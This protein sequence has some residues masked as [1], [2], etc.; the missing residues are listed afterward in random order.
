MGEVEEPLLI[1]VDGDKQMSRQH[2]EFTVQK[3]LGYID[4]FDQNSKYGSFLLHN[5]SKLDIHSSPHLAK[6]LLPGDTIR[7]S[8]M[9]VVHLLK[10]EKK[11]FAVDYIY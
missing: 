10:K 5:G 9:T 4:Y 8:Q 6:V 3:E 7:L 2:G 11:R 1:T